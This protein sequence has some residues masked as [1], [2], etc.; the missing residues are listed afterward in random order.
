[1]RGMKTSLTRV[2]L[3]LALLCLAGTAQAQTSPAKKELVTRI[4]K[5]QQ[6]GI[7]T[8]ARNVAERPALQYLQ[9]ASVV[10]QQ[11]VPA[12]K[13][14]AL[15]KDIQ[16]DARKYADDVVPS[17]TE[18]ATKIAP[19]TIGKLLD[20]KFSEDELK[21]IVAFLESAVY[22]KYGDLNDD[23]QAVLV[24]KLVADTRG[25][26]EPKIKALDLTISGRLKA[27]V[28]APAAAPKKGK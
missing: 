13:Q 17:V 6:A 16:A 23:M 15:M 4:L 24:E 5:T 22:K 10:V 11:R 9:Q 8:L 12:D 7:E 3:A 20:E 1:M 26:I 19:D 28:D 21:Q 2:S 14:E 27:A 18:R 25:N